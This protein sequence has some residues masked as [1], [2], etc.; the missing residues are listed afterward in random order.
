[1]VRLAPWTWILIGTVGIAVT[2]DA[3]AVAPE[4]ALSL[5]Y[6]N[7]G[8]LVGG[9]PFRETTF[10]TR[11][12]AHSKSKVRW[13]TPE[14]LS[15]LNRAARTVAR[16]FPGSVL[17]IGELSS[18]E[19]GRI[20]SHLSH[21]N[22]RDADVSFYFVDTAGDPVR[23]PKFMRCDPRGEGR[24][25]PTVRF[26]EK[27]NWA[28]VRALLEDS[29]SEVRQIFIYAPLRARL[30]AYAA[31]VGAPLKLRAKA[32]A[33]M[34]Q[35]INALP[36]DDHFHIRISCPADQ[37]ELGCADLP[38][39][40]APGSPDEFG[41]ELLAEAPPMADALPHAFP[42]EAWG[43]LSR[44]WS[45]EHGVCHRVDP[46][47]SVAGDGAVCED[48]SVLRGPAPLP[49]PPPPDEM[50]TPGEPLCSSIAFELASVEPAY[51]GPAAE[52]ITQCTMPATGAGFRQA[53]VAPAV[54][55]DPRAKNASQ[56]FFG[57][58]EFA[59]SP[60]IAGHAFPCAMPASW[61]DC[62]PDD[63]PNACELPMAVLSGEPSVDPSARLRPDI[64]ALQ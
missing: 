36:H 16:K 12:P 33:A 34:M 62:T 45:A 46:A 39:W 40:R 4:H 31:K 25:D 57:P 44:L 55:S 61:L 53:A 60:A 30:L 20:A 63:P 47:C 32:A 43:P 48:W 49:L 54:D 14:L 42:L 9:K 56:P 59:R 2:R 6:T 50:G 5:G 29:E 17:E 15:V 8:R 52:P 37:V 13:A 23:V 64:S 1:M 58:L 18:R 21:Q 41:P 28:F 19:G 11:T 35:P 3:R 51:C 7:A 26:D 27:R 38:L 22:G 10:I 24:D